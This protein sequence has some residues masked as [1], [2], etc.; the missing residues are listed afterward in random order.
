[1]SLASCVCTTRT[2]ISTLTTSS[3][4][5]PHRNIYPGSLINPGDGATTFVIMTVEAGVGVVCGCL[6][7]CK[8]LMSRMFPRVF[9]TV[10]NSNAQAYDQT[11]GKMLSGSSQGSLSFAR[12]PSNRSAVASSNLQRQRSNLAQNRFTDDALDK[13]LPTIPEPLPRM[14][15]RVQSLSFGR[16]RRGSRGYDYVDRG[17]EEMFIM[18]KLP[19]DRRNMEHFA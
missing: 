1:V 6:P 15:Q 9:G 5:L 3:V 14:P 16:F 8:P 11:P 2:Y 17:S 18:Q 13:P 4:S 7:G 12:R 10:S 19:G